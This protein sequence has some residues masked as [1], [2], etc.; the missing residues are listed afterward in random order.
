[1]PLF[2]L[3]IEFDSEEEMTR[4]LLRNASAS[5]IPSEYLRPV[6]R[7]PVPNLPP[8]P[9]FHATGKV[10]GSGWSEDEIAAIKASH[11]QLTAKAL[12]AKLGRSQSSV[13]QKLYEMRK[14][15]ELP[16]KYA[17]RK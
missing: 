2:C 12:G 11:I 7:A 16:G 17:K 13:Q 15:G 1:M 9:P 14:R 4:Y 6:G 3:K 8:T 5:P 10:S